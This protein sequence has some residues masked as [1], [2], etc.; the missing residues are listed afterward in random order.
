MPAGVEYYDIITREE[1]PED[2]T[3]EEI[4]EEIK[5]KGWTGHAEA[6]MK[7][8]DLTD[9]EVEVLLVHFDGKSKM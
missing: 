3:K 4:K 9:P 1:I 5:S 8:E 2:K 6:I 7:Y